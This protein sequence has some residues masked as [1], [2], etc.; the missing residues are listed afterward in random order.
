MAV[1][2]KLIRSGP[3]VWWTM[4]RAQWALVEA[5]WLVQHR[6]TGTLAAPLPDDSLELQLTPISEPLPPLIAELDLAVARVGRHGLVRPT[7]LVTAIALQRLLSRAGVTDASVRAGVRHR[8][9]RFE[10]HAWVEWRGHRL[11]P[12]SPLGGP[13]TPLAGVNG[14]G[15]P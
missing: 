14:S 8:Q 7:C 9:G 1:L 15:T 3:R 5:R 11:D 2:T 6:P 4:M 13:F 10:A 12:S